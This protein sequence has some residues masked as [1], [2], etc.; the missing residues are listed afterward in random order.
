MNKKK[1]EKKTKRGPEDFDIF[2][3]G[4]KSSHRERGESHPL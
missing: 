2:P 1:E 3:P 4:K